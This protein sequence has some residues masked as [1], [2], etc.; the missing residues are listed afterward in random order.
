MMT[1]KRSRR[2]KAIYY[3]S[4]MIKAN[5][6]L[7]G[8][9]EN[10]IEAVR[11]PITVWLDHS[12]SEQ[13]EK[14]AAEVREYDLAI[15]KSFSVNIAEGCRI[16]GCPYI[17]WC[18]DSP[19]RALYRAEA[20]YPMNRIFVFD[21]R[22]L[23]RLRQL[24]LE[25]VYYE[26]LAANI[27]AA[28]LVSI[29]D[30]DIMRLDRDVS[31][32]GSIYDRGYYDAFIRSVPQCLEECEALLDGLCCR[33]NG[34]VLFDRAGDD[35]ISALYGA[36]SKKDR[37]LYS[38]SDRYLTEVMAL[39]YELTRRERISILNASS[40]RF[41]TVVHTNNPDR[42]RDIL[43]S[44]VL[45]PVALYSDELY[46]IYAA[47][48]INLN[49]TMRSIEC[50]VPQRVFDILSVGG[51]VMTNHQEDA[52][53]LFEPDREI[54]MFSCV[55]E[56]LDKADYYIRHEKERLEIGARGYLKVRNRYNC[57]NAIADMIS[58]L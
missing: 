50:G 4:D 14:I 34:D 9:L 20:A 6:I 45:P 28:S 44:E 30:D 37:D 54:V 52:A 58:K 29:T 48:K 39:S 19:V 46:R 40:E 36:M 43:K 42:Y 2:M 53:V 25:N 12:D 23:M 57:A 31:F 49:I 8:L 38:M 32:I 33:W 16:A 27:T 51:F 5:D 26:P 56:F 1:G 10:G 18:Y 41:K 3:D 7:Y 55:E 24:G 35:C 11:S 17:A 47:S 15:S 13:T 21:S 22:Q